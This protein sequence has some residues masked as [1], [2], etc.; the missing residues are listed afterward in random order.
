MRQVAHVKFRNRQQ[1]GQ[2]LAKV[3]ASYGH[4]R[5]IVL[6]LPRGGVPV[7]AEVAHSLH[8]P[9]GLMLVRKIGAPDQPELA[10][11]ALA[12][13][14]PPLVLRNEQ[15]I[16]LLGVDARDFERVRDR[17]IA[18]IERRRQA[19]LAGRKR[20]DVAGRTV[21]LVDDGVATGMTMHAAAKAVSA[22]GAMRVVIAV[23]VA[24]A[25]VAV[26][27]RREADT[28]VCLKEPVDLLAIGYHY[29]DFAQVGDD[30]VRR[31]LG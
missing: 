19:Y 29:D 23:P 1:A 12:D 15:V 28:V 3:L 20:L 22:Q 4:C 8:A 14:M 11:G 25:S 17:E 18:E 13:G 7:A 16:R 5:P 30:E 10:M 27:L 24:A 2:L 26:E 6:A 31:L 9:L 21:I